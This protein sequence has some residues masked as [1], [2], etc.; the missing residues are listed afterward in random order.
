MGEISGEEIIMWE[1]QFIVLKGNHNC[2]I[3]MI[4]KQSGYILLL[5]YHH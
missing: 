1:I 3:V 5:H 4:D 2:I